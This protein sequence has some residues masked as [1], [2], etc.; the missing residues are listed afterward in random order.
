VIGALGC[1]GL[2]LYEPIGRRV[3]PRLAQRKRRVVGRTAA[4]VRD[5]AAACALQLIVVLWASRVAGRQH[6]ALTALLLLV[7]AIVAGILA[8]PLLPSPAAPHAP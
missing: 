3:G 8:A 1:L 4:H 6:S 2:F 7:P 5:V